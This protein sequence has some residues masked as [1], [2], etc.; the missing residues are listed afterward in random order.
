MKRRL[1]AC[2]LLVVLVIAGCNGGT[3][4][5]SEISKPVPTAAATIEIEKE[6]RPGI[7]I[8]NDLEDFPFPTSGY[9]V[10]FV[11]EVHGNPQTKQVFQTYL[12][13]L[14][15]EAGVRDVILEEDQVYEG[16]ANA[17]V[18]GS[19]D[20]FPHNLCLRTD[21]LGIIRAFNTGLPA[22]EKVRV[23]L[24]DVDSPLPSIHQ[25]IRDLHQGLG[26]AAAAISV[27]ELSEFTDWSPK[28]QKDLVTALKEVSTGLPNILNELETV[29][30]SLKWYNLG[31]QLDENPPQGLSKY[32]APIREDVMTKNVWY[33]LSELKGSPILVFFGGGHGMKTASGSYSPVEGFISWAQRLIDS[34]TKVYSLSILGMSGKGFWHG[35]P[36]E[37]KEGSQRY[38]GVE[39]YRFE[40]GTSLSSLLE[41]YPDRDIL[42]ADL[43]TGENAKIGLPSAYLDVPASQVYDGLVIFKEFTP[44]EDACGFFSGQ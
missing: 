28:Q 37:Y 31:N 18:Q 5:V 29:D 44:M 41:R 21:I 4:N 14:Y 9:E 1:L 6:V 20:A 39:G 16:E 33:V 43:R 23:H 17:Y 30:L 34:G 32:F 22:E 36:L 19:A 35:Q 2:I 3:Q 11:G 38:E 8:S 12:E 24:V 13:R 27:P 26:S 7:Y 15:K 40:D 42:Y 10:Y 25:H